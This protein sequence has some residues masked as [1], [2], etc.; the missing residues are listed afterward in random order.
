MTHP[1]DFDSLKGILHRRTAPLPDHRQ[2]GPN[3]RYAVQD[4]ALGAFGLFFTHSPSFLAYQR[5]L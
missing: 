4:A 3:T 1:L 2:E 5:G